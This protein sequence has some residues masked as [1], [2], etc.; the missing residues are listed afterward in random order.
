MATGKLVTPGD[1][2]GV[3][4]EYFTGPGTYINGKGYIRSQ[5]VGSVKIDVVNRRIIVTHAKGKP[6]IPRQGDIVVGVVESVTNDLAFIDIVSIEGA[7]AKNTDFTGVLHISQVSREY[8]ETMYDALRP[9]DVVRARVLNSMNPYQLTIKEP[10]LGV[11]A[12]FC[13]K[14]G[15]ML[16]KKDDR[17]ICP[18]CGSVEKRKVSLLYMFR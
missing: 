17:L 6:R 11:I 15:S 10:N 4:E 2:L 12:A 16:K 3:E 9:G 5:L 18:A 1:E 13:S 14:C 7:M 8:I